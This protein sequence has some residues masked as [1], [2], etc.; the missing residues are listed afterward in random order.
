MRIENRFEVPM[1]PGEA[2]SFLMDI[3]A[4]VPCFPGAE[5][6]EQIDHDNYKGRVTVKLGPLDDG[7]QRQASHR[8]TSDEAA[9]SGTVKATLDRSQRTRQRDDA[10]RDSR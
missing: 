1:A 5:L 8:R 7:L 2:W 3:P 4:T 10:S 9:C 6:V